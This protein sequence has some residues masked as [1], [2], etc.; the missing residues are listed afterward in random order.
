MRLVARKDYGSITHEAEWAIDL[1][2]VR[3]KGPIELDN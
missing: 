3:A 2:P 1:W